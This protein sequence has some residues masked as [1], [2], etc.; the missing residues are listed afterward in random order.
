MHPSVLTG[1]SLTTDWIVDKYG[2]ILGVDDVAHLLN[3][4]TS[5]AVLRAHSD[6][7]LG[8]PLRHI[9]GLRG[10]FALALDVSTYLDRLGSTAGEDKTT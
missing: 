10:L 5:R 9:D 1:T 8:F 4:P 2:A 3:F 6:G 7:R